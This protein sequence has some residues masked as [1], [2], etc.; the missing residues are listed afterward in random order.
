VEKLK[1]IQVLIFGERHKTNADP[2]DADVV[3]RAQNEFGLDVLSKPM[4]GFKVVIDKFDHSPLANILTP[5]ESYYAI[6]E[7]VRN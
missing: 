3:F 7:R 1:R 4:P 5:E 6:Y 2:P